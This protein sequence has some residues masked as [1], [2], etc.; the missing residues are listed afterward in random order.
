MKKAILS[1]LLVLFVITPSFSFAFEP[2]H[3]FTDQEKD[4]ESGLYN[5][6]SREYDPNLGR[7]IQQDPVLKDGSLD[8][9]F[10]NNA[11]QKDLNDFLSNPQN[12]NPYSYT[13]NNPV[14][15]NDPLGEDSALVIYGKNNR[16][17][18]DAFENLAK[19][20]A[21]KLKE[22]DTQNRFDDGIYIIDGSRF[23]NWQDALKNHVDI[24]HIEYWGH[25][26]NKGL[27]IGHGGAYLLTKYESQ[28][29]RNDY[30]ITELYTRNTT[31]DLKIFLNT[32]HSA[33][34]PAFGESVS[35]V[36]SDHF[37]ANVKGYTGFV[38]YNTEGETYVKWWRRD[39]RHWLTPWR[40]TNVWT[41][42][43]NKLQS[44]W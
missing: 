9:H 18:K 7:F 8:S 37:N 44:S 23:E 11:S 12:L 39:W 26:Y 14:N 2:S 34:T 4:N 20:S 29:D 19:N 1:V 35:R 27:N 42:P 28:V 38:N 16:R 32:C 40:T 10:L 41:R 25:G 33:S 22:N 3:R 5:Y 13:R 6:G 15:Y 24:S 30:F 17:D 31:S 43:I 21:N 36:F